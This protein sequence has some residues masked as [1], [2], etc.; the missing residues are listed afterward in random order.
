MIQEV[1]VPLLDPLTFSAPFVLEL[2]EEEA[3]DSAEYQE[4]S[5]DDWYTPPWRAV[6]TDYLDEEW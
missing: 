4:A 2:I 6:A 3:E 1:L 5:G